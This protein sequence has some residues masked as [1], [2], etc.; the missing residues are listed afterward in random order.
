M[1]RLKN[2]EELVEQQGKVIDL[3]AISERH[4]E[5]RLDRLEAYLTESSCG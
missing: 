3:L 4:A 2:L 1:R 5:E